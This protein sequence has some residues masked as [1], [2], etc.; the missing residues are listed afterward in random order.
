[1]D[2]NPARRELAEKFGVTHFVNPKEVQGDIVAHLVELTKGGAD[3]SFECVGNATLMRQALE[4]AHK[5]WGKSTIIGV[6]W[7]RA[8]N[9]H[10]AV[11]V[12]DGPGV[13]GQRLRRG[14]GAD[15][16]A[17]DRGLVHGWQDQY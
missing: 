2:V 7:R 5:G 8:G 11:P 12:G 15:G 16:R 1:M 4:C 10:A 13:A 3:H 14:A 17:G 6:G 9:Q